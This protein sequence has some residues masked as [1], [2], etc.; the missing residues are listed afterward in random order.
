MEKGRLVGHGESSP[1]YI[2]IDGEVVLENQM[3]LM[4]GLGGER[5]LSLS[6]S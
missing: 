3:L 1:A 5:P 2:S 4:G 6:R